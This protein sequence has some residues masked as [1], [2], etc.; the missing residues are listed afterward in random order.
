MASEHHMQGRICTWAGGRREKQLLAGRKGRPIDDPAVEELQGF[1]KCRVGSFK[2][3]LTA[4]ER[5]DK[6]ICFISSINRIC[7]R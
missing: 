3:S 1:P 7:F 6:F 4:R 5:N 2:H